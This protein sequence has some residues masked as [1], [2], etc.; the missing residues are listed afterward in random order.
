MTDRHPSFD[1]A[2]K[3]FNEPVI[4]FLTVVRL[5][6][7]GQDDDDAY[8]IYSSTH[9]GI[10]RSSVVGSFTPLALLGKAY[11]PDGIRHAMADPAR[12]DL[13][14]L[15]QWLALNGAPKVEAL[16]IEE[17]VDLDKETRED[18]SVAMPAHALAAFANA[19]IPEEYDYLNDLMDDEG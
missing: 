10:Y 1:R 14:Q 5:I 6:G 7:W 15:D 16:L 17:G 19:K 3:H 13:H 8:Y 12:D 4:D 11:T 18:V 9:R 2:V